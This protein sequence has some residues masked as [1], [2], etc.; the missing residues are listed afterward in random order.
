MIE[1]II[2]I[3]AKEKIWLAGPEMMLGKNKS[4]SKILK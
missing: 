1:K 3:A 4:K 2:T